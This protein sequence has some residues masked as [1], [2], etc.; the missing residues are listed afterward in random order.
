ML[1]A[2]QKPLFVF[3]GKRFNILQR[4]EDGKA[5]VCLKG[6]DILIAYQ[7]KTVWFLAYGEVASRNVDKGSQE[8]ASGFKSAP[9]AFSSIMKKIFEGLDEAGL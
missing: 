9:D 1:T 8:K 7:F 4:L 3:Y 6:K 5:I 2:N